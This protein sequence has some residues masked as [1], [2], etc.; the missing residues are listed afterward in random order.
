MSIVNPTDV[1][2]PSE[3]VFLKAETFAPKGGLL[4][5][6]KLLDT[7]IEIAKKQLALNAYAAAF[8][9]SDCAGGARLEPRS[10]KVLMGLRSIQALYAEPGLDSTGWPQ[11]SLE[12]HLQSLARRLQAQKGQ[13]EVV[14]VVYALLGQDD[15]DPF[16]FAI[17][18]IRAGLAQRGLLKT[19][20]EKRLKVVTVRTYHLPEATANLAATR[21]AQIQ[22]LLAGCR[23]Q[24]PELWSL[25]VSQ[26][27]H[28]IQRRKESSEIDTGSN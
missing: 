18:L 13:N 15:Y 28:G 26:V 27:D 16:G 25:L 1:L 7:P 5:K 4:D 9:A 2:T 21:E 17:N 3:V 24:R 22:A 8:L 19:V 12:G 10:K 6:Y 20:D 14:N 23:D 11:A